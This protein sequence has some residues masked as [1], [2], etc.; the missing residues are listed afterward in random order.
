VT[1]AEKIISFYEHL[2]IDKVP[3]NREVMNPFSDVDTFPITKSFYY[4]YYNDELP[5]TMILGIN[6]G[7]FG[8]GVTGIPFTDPIKLE[9]ECGIVNELPKK[10][11]LSAD[12]IYRMINVYGGPISFYNR[13][14]FSAV[15]PLGFTKNGKNAN[16]YDMKELQEGLHDFIVGSLQKQINFGMNTE[17]CFCLGEG[18]NFKF[19]SKL[20]MKYKFFEKV[21]PLAHPRFIMQYRRKKID[22]Y[23]NNYVEKFNQ[24]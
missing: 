6:P 9:K 2:S 7:R 1:I 23:I 21:I 3:E 11:E 5:R 4:K 20:N 24:Y 22:F 17:V 15:S 18:Q 19:L 12:F 13:F 8:G 14:Y 16:Y 10:T